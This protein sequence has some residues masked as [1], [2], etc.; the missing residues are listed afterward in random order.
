MT[1]MVLNRSNIKVV[2]GMSIYLVLSIFAA[3]LNDPHVM[4]L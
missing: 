4:F 2:N 3:I 1:I